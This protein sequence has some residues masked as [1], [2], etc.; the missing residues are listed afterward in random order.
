MFNHF[1]ASIACTKALRTE[2]LR[3][4]I[5]TFGNVIEHI[6]YG[7]VRILAYKAGRFS[8][9]SVKSHYTVHQSGMPTKRLRLCM[10]KSGLLGN[11]PLIRKEISGEK[12]V[13]A[14]LYDS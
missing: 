7:T 8:E 11:S 3:T 9:S 10:V 5:I 6:S 4:E 2:K 13:V 14:S 1:R 12:G